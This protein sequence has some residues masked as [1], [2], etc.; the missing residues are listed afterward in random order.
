MKISIIAP[1]LNEYECIDEFINRVQDTINRTNYENIDLIFIDDGSDQQFLNLLIE[2]SKKYS[3]IK[4]IRFKRNYGHQMAILAGYEYSYDKYDISIS[5]DS[6]LQDPPEL[7]YELINI[8]EK[9]DIN[10]VYTIRNKNDNRSRVKYFLS[11]LFYS[12]L[13][14]S[15]K[16][17]SLKF[18]GD[19]RLIDKTA[20]EYIVSNKNKI[21]FIRGFLFMNKNLKFK[22]L[23]FQRDQRFGGVPKYTFSKLYKLAVSGLY[24]YLNKY[25]LSNMVLIVLFGLLY[26][27]LKIKLMKYLIIILGFLL[28]IIAVTKLIVFPNLNN[29]YEI[30]KIFT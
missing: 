20:L 10:I 4:I 25:L 2:N 26:V 22:T 8:Y 1:V 17:E 15:N 6:D 7:I 30:R 3:N 29:N 12:I 23:N 9:N 24:P 18:A 27:F 21:Y 16:N 28:V 5:I 19:F 14:I 13:F 11:N